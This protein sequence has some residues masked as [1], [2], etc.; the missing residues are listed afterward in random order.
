M[1][2]LLLAL[3]LLTAHPAWAQVPKVVTDIAPVHALAATVMGDLGRPSLLIDQAA[4]PHS[5]QM[6]P[7]QARALS[8]ADLVIW[9]GPSLTPWLGR[10][11][12]NMAPSAASR[13]LLD[14]DPL[15][16]RIIG[17][18]VDF[19]PGG[20]LFQTTPPTPP[21]A[22]GQ[23]NEEDQGIV[24]PHAW[25]DPAN[26]ARFLQ[27]IAADLSAA[28]PANA[29]IYAANAAAAIQR[30]QRFDTEFRQRATPLRGLTLIAAHDAYRYFILR[31]DLAMTGSLTDTQATP[32]GAARIGALRDEMATSE[33]GCIL[34]APASNPA[35]IASLQPG[36][37]F[38]TVQLDATGVT[39]PLGADLYETLIRNLADA[40]TSCTAP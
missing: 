6:R 19:T 5:F 38:R 29:P 2:R 40:L 18:T 31:Y 32:P 26:A 34:A 24:D 39:L 12:A 7:S 27:V 17:D 16:L 10:A 30:L 33:R 4:D 9:M 15:P 13:P 1:R 25:L 22:R 21:Q 20:G 8:R 36:P 28:D 37:G 11:Q 14:L 3:T 23:D 35:L